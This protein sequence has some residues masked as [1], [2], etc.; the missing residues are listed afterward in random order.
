MAPA[1]LG[2]V[3]QSDPRVLD[4]DVLMPRRGSQGLGRRLSRDDRDSGITRHGVG[5]VSSATLDCHGS[6]LLERRD[7]HPSRI[8]AGFLWAQVGKGA[9]GKSSSV[10]RA[11][12]SR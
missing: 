11:A 10:I 2:L 9:I 1:M 6:T 12:Y 8:Q 3:N 5:R 4:L 7:P